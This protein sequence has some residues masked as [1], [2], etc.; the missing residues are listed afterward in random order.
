MKLFKPPFCLLLNWFLLFISFVCCSTT[1][2]STPSNPLPSVKKNISKRLK[3][4]PSKEE[5]KRGI[6]YD[7][8]IRLKVKRDNAQAFLGPG[9]KYGMADH[10]LEKGELLIFLGQLGAWQ[11]VF[12]PELRRILWIHEGFSERSL[13][14][15]KKS[16]HAPYVPIKSFANRR[17]TNKYANVRSGP[18]T[19]YKLLFAISKDSVV[20]LLLQKKRWSKVWIPHYDTAGWIYRELLNE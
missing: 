3:V 10:L 15:F 1:V 14:N 12:I 20:K 11:K 16:D 4:F 19:S 2:N 9:Q 13:S 8:C 18:S 6:P 7:F 17:I 5:E